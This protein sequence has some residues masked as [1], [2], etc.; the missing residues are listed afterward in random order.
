MA[1]STCLLP[2]QYFN[3]VLVLSSAWFFCVCFSVSKI[4]F[5]SGFNTSVIFCR[6][7][8]LNV[9]SSTSL[10]YLLVIA[11]FWAFQPRWSAWTSLSLHKAFSLSPWENPLY[12]CSE[13]SLWMP[14]SLDEHWIFGPWLPAAVSLQQASCFSGLSAVSDKSVAC[15]CLHNATCWHCKKNK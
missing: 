15:V 2:A 10:P 1:P 3:R 6:T 11:G 13:A 12:F 5:C 9:V 7:A 8:N 4:Y 14:I